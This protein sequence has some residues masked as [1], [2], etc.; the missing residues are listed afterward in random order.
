M[1]RLR[2]ET[3][4]T[5]DT[6]KYPFAE[7]VRAVLGIPDER[8]LDDVH[9]TTDWY[10]EKN[11]NRISSY[12]KV[13]NSDR[14]RTGRSLT[15]FA[16][17]PELGEGRKLYSRFEEVYLAFIHEVVAPG[18]GGGHVQ[19]QRAPTIR[20]MVPAEYNSFPDKPTTPLHND[21]DYHHQPSELN[22]W[23]PLTHVWDTNTLWVESEPGLGDLHPLNL[24]YGQYCRFYGNQCRHRTFPNRTGKTRVSLDFRAVS[25]A[26]GGH[27]PTFRK[28]R[29]RGAKARFQV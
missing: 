4:L 8:A 25:A 9:S 17:K 10:T 23:L 24:D 26:S 18:L 27:D 5:F 1:Q 28:G 3:V 6:S 11:G 12:Q 20:F 2:K 7:T 16:Y 29:R 19:Y 21:M 22:F 15:V 13:W 14:D